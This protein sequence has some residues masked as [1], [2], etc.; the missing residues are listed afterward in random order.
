MS[1]ELLAWVSNLKNLPISSHCVKYIYC[2]SDT[3]TSRNSGRAAAIESRG[4]VWYI[5]DRWFFF[6]NQQL[7]Q[8]R[9][10]NGSASYNSFF[11]VIMCMVSSV[12]SDFYSCREHFNFEYFLANILKLETWNTALKNCTRTWRCN[13]SCFIILST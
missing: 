4:I 12:S 10:Q 5:T 8:Q 2:L 6:K 7:R 3:V 9:K 1:W 11:N 13:I